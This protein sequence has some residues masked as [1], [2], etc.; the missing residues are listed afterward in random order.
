MAPRPPLDVT[1]S[2]VVF[3]TPIAD[4][5]ELIDGLLGQR[6]A[7]VYV[8]DNSPIGFDSLGPWIAPQNCHYIR[9]GRNLGYGRAHNLA[10]RDC[11]TS[12]Y[13]VIC[14]PDIALSPTVIGELFQFMEAYQDIGVCMPKL[15]GTDGQ[16]Q[17]CCRRSP[18]A[19][20]YLSQI[21]FRDSWGSQ[22]LRQLEMRDRD[23]NAEM[24]V[25]CLSGCFMFFR[26]DVLSKVKGF[27]E[28]FFLYFEDFDLSM[29]AR[30]LARNVYKPSSSVVHGR[31][32]AHRRSWRLKLAF[33]VSG[34]R[35]FLKW[36]R[37]VRS[38]GE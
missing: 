13:H 26:S 37:F 1:A 17:Y 21:F 18:V 23:Y 22:R 10:I 6:V 15:V 27:D 12:K 35:Y 20:D 32:S 31:Q 30:E 28:S 11:S 2:I 34:I 7:R 38:K 8:V 9:T 16:T 19:W 4:I 5:A 25:E 29:R 36:R 14:N 24:D 3:N 33:A